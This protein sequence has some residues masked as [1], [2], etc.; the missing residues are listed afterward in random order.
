MA[1]HKGVELHAQ[2]GSGLKI[3]IVVAQWNKAITNSLLEGAL[4]SLKDSSV[5]EVI[6]EH[7]PGSFELP[8]AADILIKG[9][10][11]DAV[12]CIGCL[13]KGETLH[14]EYISDSVSHGIMKLGLESGVPVIFG[15]L[16]CLNSLQ[17]EKRA[18]LTADGHNHGLD[19]GTTAVSMALLK[20]KYSK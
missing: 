13:I 15:V 18:G 14:F 5:A 3:G 19:W 12:I 4:K 10:K 6:I 8:M 9:K 11:L 2:D 20:K 7:V 16:T 17:A 1:F